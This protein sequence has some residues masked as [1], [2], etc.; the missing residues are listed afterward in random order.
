MKIFNTEAKQSKIK[1]ATHYSEDAVDVLSI[2][3]CKQGRLKGVEEIMMPSV[4]CAAAYRLDLRDGDTCLCS[5][6]EGTIHREQWC[7]S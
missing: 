4:F 3:D 2:V 5:P 1:W 7:L 6:W